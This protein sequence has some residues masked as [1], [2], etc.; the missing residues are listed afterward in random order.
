MP[1]PLLLHGRH[2]GPTVVYQPFGPWIVPWRF[3][4]SD[5]EYQALRQGAGL[6]DYSTQALLEI[7]G[8]DRA[9]FLHRV[10]SQDVRN[11]APGSGCSAAL[12]TS[13][14]KLIAELVVLADAEALWLLCDLPRA[15]LVARTLE[16]YHFSEDVRITN[17][18]RRFGVLALHGPRL[19]ELLAHVTGTRV[20]LPNPGDHALASLGGIPIR[21]VRYT[22]TGGPGALILAEA[23]RLP[24]AWELLQRRGAPHG[25]QLAGWEA[26]NTAR[27]EAGIPWFGLDMDEST[28]LPETGLEAVAASETKGCYVGQEIIARLRTYGSLSKRLMGLLV[29]GR[30]VPEPG[31]VI[32]YQGAPAGTLTSAAWSPA[33]GRPIGMGY[34]R[35]EAYEAGTPVEIVSADTRLKAGVAARPLVPG[36]GQTPS[37]MA[38]PSASTRLT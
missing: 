8:L 38:G 9:D 31:D 28:L 16:G 20:S 21:L 14:A 22:L 30:T 12:L 2:A 19:F 27:I 36:L 34:V 4:Q 33:L 7:R 23:D 17:R 11:L 37:P 1:I 6:T 18:E 32:L 5:A 15:E 24:E 29:E 25:L 10:L 26:L 13:S 35:R 3:Q